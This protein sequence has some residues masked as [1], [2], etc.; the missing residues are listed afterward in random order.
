MNSSGVNPEE[1]ATQCR[2]FRS[3]AEV[4]VRSLWCKAP[5]GP[6]RQKRPDTYFCVNPEPPKLTHHI[7]RKSCI[8]YHLQS[9]PASVISREVETRQKG[10]TIRLRDVS[11]LG[12]HGGRRR[13]VVVFSERSWLY[14]RMNRSLR[15]KDSAMVSSSEHQHQD[16]SLSFADAFSFANVDFH[17]IAN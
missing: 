11:G 15:S 9:S 14:I 7:Q 10:L 1:L 16:F 4:I 8:E 13:T 3:R 17:R 12:C 2:R 5:E 6:F